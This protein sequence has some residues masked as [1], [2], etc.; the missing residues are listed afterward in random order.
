MSGRSVAVLMVLAGTIAFLLV[1]PAALAGQEAFV[2][3]S[4][5]PDDNHAAFHAC[6]LQAA[7][8]FSPPRT[9]RRQA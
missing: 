6:A 1:R 9:P 3:K 2:S 7:S 8:S 5:C 4:V